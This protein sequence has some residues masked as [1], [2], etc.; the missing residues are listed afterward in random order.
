MWTLLIG[1]VA[2]L[3]KTTI[4]KIWGDKISEAEKMQ[5]QLEMQKAMQEYDW[6]GIEKEYED[7]ASARVLA[8]ADVAKG[9]WFTNI[10]AAT[11]RPFFGY[12]VMAAFFAPL[13]FRIYGSL[14]GHPLMDISMNGIE[15][16][17]ALSVVYFYFGGRTVE[18]G[19]SMWTKQK[20]NQ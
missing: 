8:A 18:K 6:K 15:K 10:L 19:I 16:E 1:P 9:N 17:I 3:L 2:D 12:L 7:R 11:V 14:T 13:T 5:L 20:E 4:N